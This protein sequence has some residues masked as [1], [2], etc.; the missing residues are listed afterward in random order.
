MII[1][2]NY[3]L[4]QN[5]RYHWVINSLITVI[6]YEW[7]LSLV[8]SEFW[9][10]P[11]HLPDLCDRNVFKTAYID[12]YQLFFSLPP[13][14]QRINNVTL[15]TQDI[16][17]HQHPKI[18]SVTITKAHIN[19]LLLRHKTFPCLVVKKNTDLRNATLRFVN[20]FHFCT[21][22]ISRGLLHR[23]HSGQNLILMW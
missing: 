6:L 4:V 9:H 12:V 13:L 8:E 19:N 7:W 17:C 18:G 2:I 1:P 21:N 15:Q 10:P 14:L 16:S 22:R 5:N 11:F 3:L 23:R 20:I